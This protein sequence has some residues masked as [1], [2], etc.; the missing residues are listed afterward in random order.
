MSKHDPSASQV[1][2]YSSPYCGYCAATGRLL[3][4]KGI[5][6]LELNVLTDPERRQ[7]MVDLTGN[8]TVPQ[9]LIGGRH[10]GGYAELIDLEAK[11]QLDVLLAEQA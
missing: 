8:Q 11:G 6:F 4:S 7:Q 5:D 1:V 10:V 3:R 9:I 2:V